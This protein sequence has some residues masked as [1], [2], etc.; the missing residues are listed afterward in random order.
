MKEGKEKDKVPRRP[1]RPLLV[2]WS[3][4]LAALLVVST[5][6]AVVLAPHADILN[7]LLSKGDVT[8]ESAV[9]AAQATA[10]I[11][12]EVESEA[13]ILLKERGLRAAV[14]HGQQGQRLRLHR[15]QTTSALAGP[16]RVRATSPRTWAST[17]ALRT[18]GIQANPTLKAFYDANAK[19][20]QQQALGLVGT[21]WNLYE[22]P[23]SRL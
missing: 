22:L 12:E 16:V 5:A 2:L 18:S 3:L 7:I 1:N 11:T 14:G 8:S 19:S 10:D 13:V 20:S 9:Q 17:R 21:D 4:V 6:L 23:Q 15:R